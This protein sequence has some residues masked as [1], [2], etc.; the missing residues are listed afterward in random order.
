ML[1]GVPRNN[2]GLFID[3]PAWTRY[4][5]IGKNANHDTSIGLKIKH[6]CWRSLTNE[7]S[8]MWAE[9]EIYGGKNV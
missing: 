2:L 8:K 3:G 5:E 1:N 7:F 6:T 9:S 4:A